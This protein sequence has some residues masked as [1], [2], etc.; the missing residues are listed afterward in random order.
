MMIMIF[1][2]CIKFSSGYIGAGN[3]LLHY[4]HQ[5]HSDYPLY[6]THGKK[7]SD[8]VHCPDPEAISFATTWIKSILSFE[9]R[10]LWIKLLMISFL[11]LWL[12]TNLCW[13]ILLLQSVVAIKDNRL[14]VVTTG[15]LIDDLLAG[16][17]FKMHIFL[18]LAVDVLS[19]DGLL[20]SSIG[21]FWSAGI[22]GNCAMTDSTTLLL[23]YLPTPNMPCWMWVW[24][25]SW[26]KA[27]LEWHDTKH[28][29]YSSYS[30]VGFTQVI[31]CCPQR[32]TM[33]LICPHW[34]KEWFC[35]ISSGSFTFSTQS[36]F[37]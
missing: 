24:R 21:S 31:L 32:R 36:G 22:F 13:F 33:A 7:V 37:C 11:P 23:V 19:V 26:T 8:I 28:S 10:S 12:S 30:L 34:Y 16:K 9:P 3:Q 14:L 18:L 17:T 35:S 6:G 29:S 1:P 2:C 20:L 4:D 5:D 25:K 27:L 15:N